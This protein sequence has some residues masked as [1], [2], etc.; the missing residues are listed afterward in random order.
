MRTILI[1]LLLTGAALD[2]LGQDTFPPLKGE[3]LKG[4]TVELPQGA[5]GKRTVLGLAYGQ[6]AGNLLEAWMEPAYLRLVAKHGLFAGSYDANVWFVPMFVGVNKA[7]YEPTLKKFRKSA[8]PEVAD[9]V[10]FF[11][12]ELEPFEAV[13]GLRDRDIPY[14]F[15]LDEQGRIIHRTSGA[16]HLDKLD[17][18]EEHLMD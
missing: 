6:K 17:T 10:L 7:A 11:Q 16:F 14:F 15:V 5:S 13:L 18:I 8:D 1:S 3:T 9:H 12:G 4:N 2:T